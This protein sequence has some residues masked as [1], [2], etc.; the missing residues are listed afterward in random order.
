MNGGIAR[1]HEIAVRVLSDRFGSAAGD[2]V[3]YLL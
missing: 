3:R 2:L 1:G